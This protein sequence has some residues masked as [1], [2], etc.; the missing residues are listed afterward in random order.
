MSLYLFW[1]CCIFSI[2]KHCVDHKP[3]FQTTTTNNKLLKSKEPNK[4]A[5]WKVKLV[6]TEDVHN[7]S[8][9]AK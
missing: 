1:I 7:F 8:H 6:C 3:L 4:E 5:L 2:K 9:Q